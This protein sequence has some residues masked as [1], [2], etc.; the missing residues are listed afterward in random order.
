[1]KLHSKAVAIATAVLAIGLSAA[2]NEVDAGWYP[3]RLWE[4]TNYNGVDINLYESYSELRWSKGFND[5]T[6]SAYNLDSVAWVLYDDTNYG[7]RRYCIEP[8]QKI[9]NL[10]AAAWNF[11]DKISSAKRLSTASCGNYPRF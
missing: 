2:P 10:H 8:G 1:M 6:S 5:L 9:A 7:D 4:H 3:L 11:G